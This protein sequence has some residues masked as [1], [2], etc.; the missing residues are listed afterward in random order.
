M[1]KQRVSFQWLDTLLNFIQ[2]IAQISGRLP[3]KDAAL[4]SNIFFARNFIRR[5]IDGCWIKNFLQERK[6]TFFKIELSVY[7]VV[8]VVDT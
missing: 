7:N 4:P 5:R 6:G 3:V 1:N 8:V 2:F